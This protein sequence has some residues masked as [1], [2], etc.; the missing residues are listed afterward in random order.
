MTVVDPPE[1]SAVHRTSRA[2]RVAGWRVGVLASP[3]APVYGALIGIFVLAWIIVTIHGGT[4][5]TVPNIVN[6]LQRSVALGIVS[7]GQTVVILLGSLDLSVAQLISLASLVAATTMDGKDANVLPA[8]L[9]VLAMGVGVGLA[10]GLII[11]KLRVNAFIATLGTG[12]AFGGVALLVAHE[13][14]IFGGIPASLTSAIF[15]P[16]SIAATNSGARVISLCS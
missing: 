11:T 10:N 7:A 2:E 6:M 9:L 1:Q 13:N 4:F 14:V 3:A 8:I 15:A 16:C 5:V 12:S